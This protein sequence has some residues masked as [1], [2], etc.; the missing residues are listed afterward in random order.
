MDDAEDFDDDDACTGRP[1]AEDLRSRWLQECRAVK[2]LEAL[3]RT[4]RGTLGPSS[5]LVAARSARDDAERCWRELL[6]PKPVAVRMGYAQKKYDRA[7]RA[8][9]KAY[10]ELRDFDEEVE[11]RRAELQEAAK[12]AEDRRDARQEAL[13]DLHQEAGELASQRKEHGSADGNRVRE[14][15]AKELQAFVESLEEG[16]D[17]RGR[18][19][20]LLAKVASVVDREEYQQYSICTDGEDACGNDEGAYQ[21]V[22]RRAR[23]SQRPQVGQGQQRAVAWNANAQ[24]R[25]NRHSVIT[26]TN[27]FSELAEAAVPRAGSGGEHAGRA[28]DTSHVK[29][30]EPSTQEAAGASAATAAVATGGKGR[31]NPRD[32]SDDVPQPP[33]GKSHR[34][35][36]EEVVVSVDAAG[37][38]AARAAKLKQE[39]DAA[40][41]AA[42]EVGATFGDDASV[43]IAGQL[44]AHK[45]QLLAERAK[46]AGIEPSCD[47]KPLIGLSP[48]DLNK[49][50]QGVLAPA[51]ANGK[52]GMDL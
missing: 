42:R 15:V 32:H 1:T 20:L 39:Q 10:Q 14:L 28:D 52:E 29:P 17:A 37:D 51:E 35:E 7:Q 48:H 44:Y 36:D 41:A 3:E 16:S 49:W 26:V 50:V 43:Q 33:S 45:V 47:G 25:W 19:N 24:G 11:R 13:D 40:I 31:K 5:A 46:A 34:G 30:V 38:D 2:A 9:D 8:V 6:T 23:A 18:A 21:A 27:G 22:T 12:R 4:E